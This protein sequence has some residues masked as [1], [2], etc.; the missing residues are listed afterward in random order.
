MRHPD[1]PNGYLNYSRVSNLGCRRRIQAESNSINNQAVFEFQAYFESR[2]VRWAVFGRVLA[3]MKISVLFHQCFIKTIAAKKKLALEEVLLVLSVEILLKSSLPELVIRLNGG[4]YL[5]HSSKL[6]KNN[7]FKSFS[8][9]SKPPTKCKWVQG[10]FHEHQIEEN[11]LNNNNGLVF[12]TWSTVQI[13]VIGNRWKN[14]RDGREND[15]N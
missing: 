7:L 12:L 2:G 15:K 14:C 4:I 13:Q 9:S 1:D 10:T 6:T 8:V 3:G 11:L 5:P